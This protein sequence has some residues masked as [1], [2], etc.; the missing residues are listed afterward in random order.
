MVPI[1]SRLAIAAAALVCFAG[2]SVAA[3]YSCKKEITATGNGAIT[4]DGGKKKA[5]KVWRDRA[6]AD[7]GFYY[8]DEKTAN[9]GLGVVVERC[10]RSSIGLMVCEAKGKP[11]VVQTGNDLECTRG[12]S[13]NCDAKSKWIQFQLDKRGYD[14]GAVDGSIGRKTERAIEKFKKDQ[15]IASDNI[16]DVIAALKK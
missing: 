3:D 2:A 7:Y 13:S 8:G 11:C 1:L 6:I 12:D 5:I 10:A 4:E 14:V 16:E 15:K 9:E